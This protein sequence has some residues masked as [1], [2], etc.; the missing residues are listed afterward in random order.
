M[1]PDDRPDG[2]APR[3][4]QRQCA[5]KDVIELDEQRS[6][7]AEQRIGQSAGCAPCEVSLMAEGFEETKECHRGCRFQ[8]RAVHVQWRSLVWRTV[9]GAKPTD[10]TIACTSASVKAACNESANIAR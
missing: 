6:W 7:T 10:S 5:K 8:A 4:P 1:H 9:S 3:Y 2:D